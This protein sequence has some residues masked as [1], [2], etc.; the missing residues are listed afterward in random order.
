MDLTTRYLGL[1]LPHP[2]IAGAGPLCDT[3]DSARRL[4]DAGAA[5]VVLRSLFEEQ[6]EQ[7]ALATHD[8]LETHGEAFAEAT[9]Y[10]PEP[11]GFV[12]GPHAYLEHVRKLKHTL[13]VPVIASLNGTTPGGWVRYATLIEQAGADALEL[14]VFDVPTDPALDARAIEDQTVDLV[15]QVCAAVKIP[16]AVKLSIRCT[17]PVHIAR[18][19]V[20][21]GAAGLVVFNRYFEPEVDLENLEVVSHLRLSDSHELG[22]RLRWLAILSARVECPLAVTGGV[23]TA[24][25]A[26]KAIACGASAVQ[27]VSALL[28]RGPEAIRVIRDEMARWLEE[29][30]YRNLAEARGCL[31]LDRCP[32]PGVYV[33]GNYLHLLQTF[34]QAGF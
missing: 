34:S 16:V 5:A 1:E 33:R 27:L 15:R 7:E 12:L 26:L 4:E 6:I 14:N 21:A 20:E 9:S 19:L 13:S 11:P 30:E 24:T 32:D 17:A 25:D 29:H 28:Q 2:L 10:L 22:L 18:R 31:N 23:H 8:A 3:L